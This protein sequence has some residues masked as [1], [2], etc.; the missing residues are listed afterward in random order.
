MTEMLSCAERAFVEAVNTSLDLF[1]LLATKIRN[2]SDSL[3]MK[4]SSDFAFLDMLGSLDFS[5]V[6]L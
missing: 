5:K 3:I 4:V 6:K 2:K 1:T